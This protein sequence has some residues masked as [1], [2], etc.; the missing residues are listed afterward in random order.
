MSR[1]VTSASPPGRNAIPQGT[2]RSFARTRGSAAGPG[3]SAGE[4]AA[5]D[6]GGG[7]GR[8]GWEAAGAGASEHPPASTADAAIRR[9]AQ[10]VRPAP[11]EV[12][13]VMGLSR[14]VRP[15]I[16]TRPVPRKGS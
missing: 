5:G 2:A 7:E 9:A 10:R 4:V 13:P 14:L 15:S 16:H 1:S 11:C 12:M 8:V 6:P 3:S